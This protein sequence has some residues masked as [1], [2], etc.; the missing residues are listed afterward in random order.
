MKPL[1]M[2]VDDNPEIRSMLRRLL[3]FEETWDVVEA[4]DGEIALKT[5]QALR[6]AAVLLDQMLPVS[7]G[8]EIAKILREVEGFEGPLLLYSS[9]GQ[10]ASRIEADRLDVQIIEK[11]EVTWLLEVLREVAVGISA[12]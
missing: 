2:L 4:D 7:S 6:P 11:S 1:L 12:G 5:F 8:L 3:E 10:L 9:A